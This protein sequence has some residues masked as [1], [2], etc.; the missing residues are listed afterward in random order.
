MNTTRSSPLYRPT[1]VDWV[2]T[3]VL[4]A[5]FGWT[6]LPLSHGLTASHPRARVYED[7]RLVREVDLTADAVFT[8]RE[9]HIRLEVKDGRTRV[10]QSDC[11]GHACEQAGWISHAPQTIVCAPNKVLIM[12][13]DDSQPQD[14][15][16]V[17]Y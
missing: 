1:P 9:G 8:V 13:V 12:F 2:L 5:F 10:V 7:G 4:L 17:S 3:L 16:A 6:F 15:D 11:P 14:Y